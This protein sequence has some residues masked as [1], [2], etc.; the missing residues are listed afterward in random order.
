MDADWAILSKVWCLALEEENR[1]WAE[2]RRPA[3]FQVQRRRAPLS[4]MLGGDR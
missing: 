3:V 4:S 1:A 2:P